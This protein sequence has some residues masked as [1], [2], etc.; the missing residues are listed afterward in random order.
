MSGSAG[1][2]GLLV[3]CYGAVVTLLLLSAGLL[4]CNADQLLGADGSFAGGMLGEASF[5]RS[6]NLSVVT[7]TL[8][9]LTAAIVGIPAAYALSRRKVP[10]RGL[11]DVLL[12]SVIVLPASSVG[13]GLIVLFQYGPL[14][15]LQQRLGFQVA[16]TVLPGI[17][18]AQLVLSLAM[19]L[20]AWRAAFDTVNPRFELVA[21]SL[22]GS[23]WRAFWTVTLPLAR[24]GLLAG[25]VLAWVR[26]MAEF[27]AVLLFCA[28][29]AELPGSRF[30]PL[31]R[32]LQLHRADILSVS[33]WS[34]IEYGELEYGFGIAFVM[35]LVSAA[36]VYSMHRLGGRGYVW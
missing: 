10:A 31:L 13:L 2:R 29:F 7:A 9:A 25:F 16:H 12:S 19:G 15:D 6:V 21:R 35:V 32:A 30:G 11:I 23:A 5:W 24:P 20:S 3:V 22:G 14:H 33:M 36:S 1:G 28:T 17:V 4:L 34:H 18:V 26:A 27:G 8:T